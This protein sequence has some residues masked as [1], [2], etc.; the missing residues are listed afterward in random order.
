MDGMVYGSGFYHGQTCVGPCLPGT[1]TDKIHAVYAN[2]FMACLN[3][4]SLFPERGA[5][6]LDT[7]MFS[8]VPDVSVQSNGSI[9][10]S[11][12]APTPHNGTHRPVSV[13]PLSSYYVPAARLT[14]P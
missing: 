7:A 12:F 11:S 10:P 14:K 9:L 4:R 1:G 3:A 5:S 8:S 13:S 6:Q 2:S